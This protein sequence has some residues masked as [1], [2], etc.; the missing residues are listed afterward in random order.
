MAPYGARARAASRSGANS[1]RWRWPR[2]GAVAPVA[3]WRG[4][5]FLAFQALTQ[6]GLEV[7]GPPVLVKQIA[8]GFVGELLKRAHA[9][10]REHIE[11][12][13]GFVVELD[14]LANH[15]DPAFFGTRVAIVIGKTAAPVPRVHLPRDRGPKASV[16]NSR[17]RP[18]NPRTNSPAGHPDGSRSRISTPGICRNDCHGGDGG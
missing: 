16:R 6:R 7:G 10:V 11:C 2:G 1:A 17:S 18:A 9:I 4:V 13:P 15:G 3:G 5:R 8:E 12:L 14:A